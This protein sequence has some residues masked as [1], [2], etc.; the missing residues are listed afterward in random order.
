MRVVKDLVILEDEAS[1]YVCLGPLNKPL[2]MLVQI[3]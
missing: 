2:N 3:A 1:D